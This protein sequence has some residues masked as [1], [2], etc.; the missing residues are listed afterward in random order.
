[1]VE[2]LETFKETCGTRPERMIIYR[3]G[4]WEG[5]LYDIASKELDSVK[6]ACN[7][8]DPGYNPQIT[9][10]A[11]QKRHH[12]R[13]FPIRREDADKSGNVLPGTVI[14]AGVTHPFEFGMDHE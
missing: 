5:H 11:V 14:D 6:E 2:L 13:F 3:D 1:M 12:A 4:V 7:M 9:F 10:I 8:I